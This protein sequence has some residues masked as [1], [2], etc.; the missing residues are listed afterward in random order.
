MCDGVPSPENAP[1]YCYF[2]QITSF[3]F[4]LGHGFLQQGREVPLI[5]LDPAIKLQTSIPPQLV[6]ANPIEHGN[7]GGV[8]L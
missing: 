6:E 8:E 1:S 3:G 4:G 5:H 7:I 2:D